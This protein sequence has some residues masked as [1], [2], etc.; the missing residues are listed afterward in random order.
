MTRLAM[1][2]GGGGRLDA[3][4]L[5]AKSL[6]N[7]RAVVAGCPLERVGEHGDRCIRELGEER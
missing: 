7:E 3:S 6:D 1:R 4:S 2:I 5:A